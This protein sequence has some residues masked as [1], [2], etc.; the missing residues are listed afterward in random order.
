[1]AGVRW[2]VDLLCIF[3][4]LATAEVHKTVS[5]WTRFHHAHILTTILQ[6]IVTKSKIGLGSGMMIAF[7]SLQRRLPWSIASQRNGTSEGFLVGSVSKD[8]CVTIDLYVQKFS[9]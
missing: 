3:P 7:D 2:R 8:I 6:S 4:V 5:A 1:M 9:K